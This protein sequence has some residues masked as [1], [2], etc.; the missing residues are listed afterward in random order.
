MKKG[1]EIKTIGN[2]STAGFSNVEFKAGRY[3]DLGPGFLAT[4]IFLAHIAP[5]TCLPD[6]SVGCFRSA[7]HT[8]VKDERI[9]KDEQLKDKDLKK[10]DLT[11]VEITRSIS[12]SPNPTNGLTT[13]AIDNF[14]ATNTN[15][16]LVL[17]NSVGQ[18]MQQL[19]ITSSKTDIDLSS[20]K[21]GIYLLSFSDGVNTSVVRI[22]KTN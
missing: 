14:D 16:K 2:V 22:S 11:I 3:I 20:Y 6:D 8:F 21:N 19:N 12:V 10:N 5:C 4:P 7:I 15:Y 9:S 17:Y 18:L 1:W 13:I